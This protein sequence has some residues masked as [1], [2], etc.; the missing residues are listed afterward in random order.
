VK[1]L[2]ACFVGL[3]VGTGAMGAGQSQRFRSGAELV[4][5]DALV[6]SGRRPITGLRIADFE[7]V[8]NGTPQSI[9]QLY[10]EQLPVNVIMVLDASSSMAGERIDALK[11]AVTLVVDRL[12]PRDQGAIV[13]FSQHLELE[14]SFTGDREKLYKASRQLSAEGST[15][16]RDAAFA[17][18]ALRSAADRRTL[19]ILVSD[20]V[21]T[22]SLLSERQVIEIARRSDVVIY[23]IGIREAAVA[24]LPSRSPFGPRPGIGDITDETFL[25]TL[26]EQTGGRFEYAGSRDIG[27]TF[28]RVLDEFNSCYVLGYAPTSVSPGGWHQVEVRVKNSKATVLARRG[29]FA[30]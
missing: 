17:G 28:A 15:A 7:L 10:V 3:L 20:G 21:D 4:T 18:L 6:T 22:A 8:D 14:A 27:N 2:V 9:Q 24:M 19:M 16:L 30:N 26:A 5:I 29:Y 23:P 12:R 25:R 13:S 1:R 11:K